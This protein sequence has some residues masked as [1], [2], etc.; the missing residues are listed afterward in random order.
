M[1]KQQLIT[2]IRN[3]FQWYAIPR[4]MNSRT[5]SELE[6]LVIKARQ[7]GLVKR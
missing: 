5:V 3:N 6:E 7:L 4:N 2:Y 1:N